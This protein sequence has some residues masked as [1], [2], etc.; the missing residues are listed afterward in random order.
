MNTND[1][2][3]T[4]SCKYIYNECVNSYGRDAQKIILSYYDV[5]LNTQIVKQKKHDYM[6]AKHILTDKWNVINKFIVTTEKSSRYEKSEIV[7]LLRFP[8]IVKMFDEFN[9]NWKKIYHFLN[10]GYENLN[11]IVSKTV[12]N[13]KGAGN[14]DTKQMKKIHAEL[15]KKSYLSDS[16]KFSSVVLYSWMFDVF[17][18]EVDDFFLSKNNKYTF[19]EMLLNRDGMKFVVSL[20]FFNSNIPFKKYD[21]NKK[22]FLNVVIERLLGKFESLDGVA[23][24]LKRIEKNGHSKKKVK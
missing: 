7:Y 24:N 22:V 1:A 6:E 18:V 16:D 9:W 4:I 2:E 17:D 5:L 21:D 15:L 3:K 13:D 11:D 19:K 10:S 14:I 23:I 12:V 8:N 20:G